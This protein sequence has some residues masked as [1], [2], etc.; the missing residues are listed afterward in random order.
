MD[1]S[2]SEEEEGSEDQVEDQ[3]DAKHAY[4]SR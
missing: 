2:N 4:Y 1:A 3:T